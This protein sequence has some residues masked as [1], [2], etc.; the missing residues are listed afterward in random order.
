MATGGSCY[1]RRALGILAGDRPLLLH[2]TCVKKERERSVGKKNL[3]EEPK[4]TVKGPNPTPA[5]MKR[6]RAPEPLA[7]LDTNGV[8]STSVSVRKEKGADDGNASRR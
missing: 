2:E 6:S 3:P 4:P 1:C 5:K 7:E 8:P